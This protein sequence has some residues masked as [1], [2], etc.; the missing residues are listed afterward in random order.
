MARLLNID[1]KTLS[2][3]VI[4]QFLIFEGEDPKDCKLYYFS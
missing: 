4:G 3:W 1:L 2:V